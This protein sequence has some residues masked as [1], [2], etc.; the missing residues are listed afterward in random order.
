MNVLLIED[1]ADDADLVSR[2]LS[3][4]QVFVSGVTTAAQ[5]VKQLVEQKPDVVLLDLK[6][7]NGEG[8]LLCK[9]ILDNAVGIPVIVLSGNTDKALVDAAL[10]IGCRAYVAK[11]GMNALTLYSAIRQAYKDATI[12]KQGIAEKIDALFEKAR[13]QVREVEAMK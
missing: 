5:A 7:P 2:A 1:D 10:N 8:I 12:F 9:R 11:D 6:L 4:T 13:R 3:D